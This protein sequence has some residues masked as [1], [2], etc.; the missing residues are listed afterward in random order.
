MN[1]NKIGIM[2]GRLSNPIN[3]KIQSFPIFTWKEEFEKASNIGFDS[4]EWIFDDF[5][6]N[7][8]FFDEQIVEIKSLSEKYQVK[9]NSLLADYFINN[10]L[11]NETQ[12]GLQKNLAQLKKIIIQCKKIGIS[13]IEIPFVDASSLNS[14]NA[15]EQLIKNVRGILP[16][17]N[18]NNVK[19]AI[20]TDL[21]PEIFL[22]LLNRFDYENIYANYDVGNSTSLGFD[23]EKELQILS[24]KIMNIHIK[25][26]KLFGK[27]M[28]LG[29]GDTNFDLFFSTI[30]KIGYAGEFII[31]GARKD[32]ESPE[33]T[34]LGYLQFVKQYLDK[35]SINQY[36]YSRRVN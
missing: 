28:P 4:I 6:D 1:S 31:Q 9:I 36:S 15:R 30:K 34:C 23:I 8:I 16:F 35:H 17:A 11:F 18:D 7:P 13:I 22:E 14:K 25:D 33:K 20:E 26:R 12:F 3:K 2:Q 29:K 21:S 32:N 24:R 27:T 19:L 5:L 10:K